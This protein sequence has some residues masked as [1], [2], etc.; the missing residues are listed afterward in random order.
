MKSIMC[1]AL[2]RKLLTKEEECIKIGIYIYCKECVE[3]K[4]KI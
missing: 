4:K 1:A 2:C 3:R